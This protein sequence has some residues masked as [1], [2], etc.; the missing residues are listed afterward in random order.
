MLAFTTELSTSADPNSSLEDCKH[1]QAGA[2]KTLDAKCAHLINDEQQGD[3][4]AISV[5]LVLGS[6]ANVEFHEST[7]MRPS[8][9]CS[10][11]GEDLSVTFCCVSFLLQQFASQDDRCVTQ[12]PK[13]IGGDHGIKIPVV[14][15]LLSVQVPG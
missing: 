6:K 15:W 9:L 13:L 10:A 5:G 7:L 3:R 11:M 12:E 8:S 1:T 14:F 4:C 2:A